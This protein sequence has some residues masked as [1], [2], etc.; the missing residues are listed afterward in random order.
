MMKEHAKKYNILHIITGLATGGAE[1]VLYNLLNGGLAKSFNN[2]IISLS[3]K[4]TIGPLIQE[5]G[6]P[7][8]T[9][10]MHPKFP[11]LSGLSGLRR[12][13]RAFQPDL[14]QGWMYHGNLVATLARALAVERPMLAW[15]IHHSLNELY[16]EKPITRQVI[17]ANRYVSSF[18][19]AIHY[20][21]QH[22]QKLH[23]EYGF[24][25]E[26]GL[27]IP[28]GINTQR[29]FFSSAA[30]QRI[31]SEL[32]IPANA[33]IIGHV[34]RFHPMK[35]HQ[36]FIQAATDL[37]NRYP[38][39]QFLLVGRNVDPYNQIIAALIPEPL[40]YRFHMLGE[41]NDVPDLMC[42]MDIFCQ[43]S[44]SEAFPVVLGEAMTTGIPCVATDVG[45]SAIIIGDT[46]VI[47]PPRSERALTAGL[48]SVL[49]MSTEKRH[50]LGEKAR[51]RIEANY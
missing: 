36:I 45:D 21:S 42:A 44:W 2:H 25:A 12:V 15:S 14:I 33:Q 48:E 3:D 13:V 16:H 20:C 29:F 50:A 40:R 35:N 30:R 37:A 17:R 31:R 19:E 43:S 32:D 51:A 47:V 38:D 9:L 49:A 24:V 11:S 34:A 4:G 41:R 7:V 27:F 46:G 28:N 18:P 1:R 8:T 10:D 39:V 26:N 6:I 5:L 23:E 22:S